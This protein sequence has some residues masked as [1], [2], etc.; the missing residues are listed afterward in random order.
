MDKKDYTLPELQ[1]LGLFLGI[2]GIY[3]KRNQNKEHLRQYIYWWLKL[4]DQA[5]IGDPTNSTNSAP[6]QV[7]EMATSSMQNSE[8]Q[9]L[10]ENSGNGQGQGESLNKT[11]S[12]HTPTQIF[13]GAGELTTPKTD[14]K[15]RIIWAMPSSPSH[16]PNFDTQKKTI[17]VQPDKKGLIHSHERKD[18]CNPPPYQVRVNA[19]YNSSEKLRDRMAEMRKRKWLRNI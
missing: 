15:T 6:E 2:P 3:S 18:V 10:D 4:D 1:E 12:Q 7:E 11:F 13:S 16:P 17:S 14:E 8:P 19:S 9:N 5:D